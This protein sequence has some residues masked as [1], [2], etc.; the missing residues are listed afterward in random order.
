MRETHESR[1]PFTRVARLLKKMPWL[2]AVKQ[3]WHDND[4]VKVE[5]T[6]GPGFL[7]GPGSAYSSYC[8]VHHVTHYDERMIRLAGPDH[9]RSWFDIL[10]ELRRQGI[11][12]EWV[13]H[14]VVPFNSAWIHVYPAPKDSS[15]LDMF[16]AHPRA[17]E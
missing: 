4:L 13:E 5:S 9:N 1:T 16:L 10:L 15:F 14:L 3:E 6:E 2:W 7:D 12:L 17:R 8:Y 11:R